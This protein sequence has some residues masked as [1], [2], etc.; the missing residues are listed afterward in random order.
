MYGTHGHVLHSHAANAFVLVNDTP[1][2][3]IVSAFLPLGPLGFGGYTILYLGKMAAKI[4]PST[5][6]LDPMAGTIAYVLGLFAALIMWG[7]GKR[8]PAIMYRLSQLT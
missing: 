6:T 7:W 1:R 8:S 4:F 3:I 5:G 2:E